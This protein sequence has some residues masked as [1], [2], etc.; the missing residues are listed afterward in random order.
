MRTVKPA[1]KFF[2]K[3]IGFFTLIR[4]VRIIKA[5]P[6]VILGAYLGSNNWHD[7]FTIKIV[8][9]VLVVSLTM[10]FSYI[11][12]DL[13]DIA[14][15]A[16]SKADRPLPS[17]KVTP[18]EARILAIIFSVCAICISITLGSLFA[19]FTLCTISVSFSYS[20]RLKNTVLLGNITVAI[21]VA[22]IIIFGSL[23]TQ[24]PGYKTWIIAILAFLLLF[25]YE[26]IHSA[27]DKEGDIA[28]G[29]ATT[30]TVLGTPQIIR[31]CQ[32]IAAT[33]VLFAILPWLL[34]LASFWYL[35][36]MALGVILPLIGIVY[37]VTTKP[38]TSSFHSSEIFIEF[39][40]VTGLIPIILLR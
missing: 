11:I 28:A 2:D 22:S 33:Y 38:T 15:D 9:G 30:G 39:L 23:L 17:G 19:L 4:L 16:I 7:I 21:L 10:A 24:G 6:F 34:G 14:V 13:R 3:I 35:L 26:I 40:W 18:Q 5:I 32:I 25:E 1:D 12:N 37:I 31:L 36:S 27:A 20:F 8:S 29:L